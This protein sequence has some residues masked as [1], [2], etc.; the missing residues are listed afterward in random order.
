VFILRKSTSISSS[1][2]NET[3]PPP[4][5][6]RKGGGALKRERE[7][8]VLSNCRNSKSLIEGHRLRHFFSLSRLINQRLPPGPYKFKQY[9]EYATNNWNCCFFYIYVISL[10]MQKIYRVSYEPLRSFGNGPQPARHECHEC[11]P[12]RI[13]SCQYSRQ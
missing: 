12:P 11:C 1:G 3:T 7:R 4:L 9:F 6:T 2:R 8:S 13:N 10:F 5:I